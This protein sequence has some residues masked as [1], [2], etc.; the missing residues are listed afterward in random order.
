MGRNKPPPDKIRAAAA[1]VRAAEGS[2]QASERRRNAT[3]AKR[4]AD[5]S[6]TGPPRL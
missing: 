5:P 2:A 4:L 6:A 3:G 1:K